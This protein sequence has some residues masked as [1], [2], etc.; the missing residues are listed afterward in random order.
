MRR[1]TPSHTCSASPPRAIDRAQRSSTL[2]LRRLLRKLGSIAPRK[3]HHF[4]R[5]RRTRRN[6]YTAHHH[7]PDGLSDT[8]RHLQ[9]RRRS[10][11][12]EPQS[13]R[14]PRGAQPAT[15][16]PATTLT[17]PSPPATAA[18]WDRN[19]TSTRREPYNTSQPCPK[20]PSTKAL[21]GGS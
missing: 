17:T 14:A 15:S 13:H 5:D 11:S 9:R 16:S 4:G 1:P 8:G 12:P 10:S 2:F 20:S 18:R 19:G 21:T 6:P 7:H 3:C